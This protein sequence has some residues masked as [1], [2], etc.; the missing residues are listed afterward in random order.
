MYHK[1][2]VCCMLHIFKMAT[3]P[4]LRS[5]MVPPSIECY[6]YT[7]YMANHCTW[8]CILRVPDGSLLAH[9]VSC[10]NLFASYTILKEVLC[11]YMSMFAATLLCTRVQLIP[12]RTSYRTCT[13]TCTV[14]CSV[15]TRIHAHANYESHVKHSHVTENTY[16]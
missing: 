13:C 15:Q 14:V 9:I 4:S 5:N 1:C 16:M 8:I 12:T 2:K 3:S 7:L 6:M 10:S 11:T